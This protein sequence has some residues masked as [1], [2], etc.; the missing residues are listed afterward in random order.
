MK[1]D[2]AQGIYSTSKLVP[3]VFIM[4]ANEGLKGA[5]LF[6]RRYYDAQVVNYSA[7]IFGQASIV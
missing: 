7:T 3:V 5:A 4:E 2:E 1:H 6:D